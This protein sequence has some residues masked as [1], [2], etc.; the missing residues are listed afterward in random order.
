MALLNRFS[1]LIRADF[2]AVL[3]HLEEPD[4]LLRQA[5]RE[6]E[7]VLEEHHSDLK[8]LQTNSQRIQYRLS[9][10]EQVIATVEKE[11]DVCFEADHLDLARGQVRRKLQAETTQRALTKKSQDL[12]HCIQDLNQQISEKTERLESLKQKVEIIQVER[13]DAMVPEFEGGHVSDDEVELAF[14]KEQR[15]R[16]RMER[17]A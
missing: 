8:H 4:L 6:M 16:T 17:S 9:E 1:R 5:I 11:L 12:P 3:D 2:H 13:P 14:L 7:T 10:L 15:R